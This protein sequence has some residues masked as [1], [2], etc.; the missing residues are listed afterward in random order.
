MK[1]KGRLEYVSGDVT[2]QMQNI[3]EDIVK[4]EGWSGVCIANAVILRGAECLDNPGEEFRDVSASFFTFCS[5]AP[6]I[7][8]YLKFRP[9]RFILAFLSHTYLL[10]LTPFLHTRQC[11]RHTLRHPSRRLPKGKT[12]GSLVPIV[13]MSGNITQVYTTQVNPL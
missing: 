7:P 11:R 2:N 12:P 10:R 13:S 4:E 3:T 1:G 8:P 5:S 9:P 6:M